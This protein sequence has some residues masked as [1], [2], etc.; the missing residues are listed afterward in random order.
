MTGYAHS[1]SPREVRMGNYID[2]VIVAQ[3]VVLIDEDAVRSLETI[4]RRLASG[5]G[6]H[7]QFLV[8]VLGPVDNHLVQ[9]TM[10]TRLSMARKL[11]SVFS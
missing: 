11:V 7:E 1:F 9:R 10:A 8:R 6:R 5:R 2:R 4:A 3:E